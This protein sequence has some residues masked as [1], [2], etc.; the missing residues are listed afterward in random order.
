MSMKTRESEHGAS[1]RDFLKIATCGGVLT[2]GIMMAGCSESEAQGVS[3]QDTTFDQET[4]VLVL[5]GGSGGCFAAN[6][7]MRQGA[8]VVIVEADSRIGGTTLLSGGFYHTW[9]IT[10]ENAA[11]MLS[12]ADPAKREF[13]INKWGEVC[14]WVI[15]ESGLPAAPLDLDYPLYGAHLKGFSTSGTEKAIG[16]QTFLE[17]LVDGATV[18]LDTYLIELVGSDD[19]SILG[20]VI[21][22]KNGV[23]QTIGAKAT[24]IATGSY[25]ANKGMITQYLGRWADC[26]VCRATPYNKGVGIA[27]ALEKGARMSKGTGHFYGHLNPWPPLTPQTEEEYGDPDFDVYTPI[28][29]AVQKFSVEGLALNTNGLRF[30]DEGPENYVG[31]NYL[32]NDLT[33]EP[34]GHCFIIIDSAQDHKADLSIISDAG[35]VVLEANTID[36]LADQMKSYKVHAQN[37]KKTVSEYQAAAV[38]DTTAEL[39]IAK[40][41]MPTGYLTKMDTPPFYAV[42][43]AA[44]ISGFYGGLETTNEGKVLDYSDTP[45]RGLFA[46]PMASGGVFYKEYGGGLALCATF[47][48][49][50]G[51]AAGAEAI[52]S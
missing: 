3:Q 31:D 9:D 14:D 45:I 7:A 39:P 43:V 16:R 47:G 24:I 18:I 19:G 22:D 46:V 28:M 30:T 32:A 40:S 29:G 13:F 17:D 38:A 27:L 1:R 34:D 15:N 52:T 41:P 26:S 33:Q 8:S 44:G 20:A 49:A 5:G 12:S 36:E 51:E 2:A 50:A 25:Q 37:V 11:E 42:Q 10:P 48:A 6:Y 23:I 35:G 4:D 21:R